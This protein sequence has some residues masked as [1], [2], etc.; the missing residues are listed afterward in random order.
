MAPRLPGV[1]RRRAHAA[2]R[3]RRAARRRGQARRAGAHLGV[4]RPAVERPL[5][6]DAITV[7]VA[8]C[9]RPASLARCLEA[10]AR[11]T[12]Q[13]REMIVVDGAPS[14]V[15]R[16]IV[17]QCGIEGARY[18]EQPPLG[19]SASRNLAL[20]VASGVVLAAPDDDCVPDPGWVT[21][22]A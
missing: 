9:G 3:E 7:A 2:G 20:A 6:G 22:L 16:R 14:P 1:A 5:R 11:G 17:E 18:L 13:P 15:T 21:A 4:L 19:L 12:A 10:L 8:T